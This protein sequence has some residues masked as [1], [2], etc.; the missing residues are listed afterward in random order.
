MKVVNVFRII[1]NFLFNK[2]NRELLM[3]LF[4][5]FLSG[6]FWLIMTLNETF[7]QEIMV[8]VRYVNI[9]KNAVLTSGETDTLR[10]QVSDRG[11]SLLTYLYDKSP[12]PLE[13]DFMK[14][15]GENGTGRVSSSEL[16]KLLNGRLSASANVVSVKPD[17]LVFY[18][19]Y[20]ETK[21]VPVRWVG[22]VTPDSKHFIS[23]VHCSAD[24]VVIFASPRLLDSIKEV[25]TEPIYQ[26][27][28]A[29]SV[30]FNARLQRIQGV[31]MVPNRV[32]LSFSTD[33]LTQLS[34]NEM[35]ITPV[36]VP[37]E[38]YLVMF[39]SK[40]N[41]NFVAGLKKYEGIKESDFTIVADYNEMER[42]G[43]LFFCNLRI[44]SMPE[45]VKNVTLST[46]RVELIVKRKES[47]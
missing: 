45:G 1:G 23:D 20:G 16:Q 41:I 28:L 19:N 37:D 17:G 44:Q 13:I 46:Q 14:Y 35:P 21:T 31:K 26:R 27:D 47:E 32:T 25:Y 12:Q 36:N 2:V 42:Q 6:I 5:V 33:I 34:F 24:S 18:Y 40:V 3:F 11:I 43:E 9:P 22:E 39:P 10:V 15:A 30:T 29:D 7:E 38:E 4:F 8:P